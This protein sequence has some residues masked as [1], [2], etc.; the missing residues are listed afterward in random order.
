MFNRLAVAAA[1][2][3]VVS[4]TVV[5][6]KLPKRPRLPGEADTNNASAYHYFGNSVLLRDPKQ[7][8]DAYYWATRLNPRLAEAYYNRRIAL[9]LENPRRLAQYW[10]GQKSV[11]QSAEMQRIDSLYWR[12]LMLNPAL[13]QRFERELILAMIRSNI[14]PSAN[15]SPAELEMEFDT[16]VRGLMRADD[17]RARMAQ[18]RGDDQRALR[19]YASA[20]KQDPKVADIR[21]ARGRLFLQLGMADS[22]ISE[23]TQA[24]DMMRKEDKKEF[25]VFYNSK[26]MLETTIGIAHQQLSNLPAARDAFGRAL[27]EDLAY[28]PAHVWLGYV[29]L[30]LRDTTTALAELD[31]AVQLRADD[32]VLRDQYGYA[33]LIAGKADAAIE[34]LKKAAE[35]E[36]YYALPQWHLGEAYEAASNTKNALEAYRLFLVR[37]GNADPN[38]E[39]VSKRIAALAGTSQ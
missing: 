35:L 13:P 7:A 24:L 28:Y 36:P 4:S 27:Q 38:R 29:A 2:L 19:L 18:S 25:V 3:L 33:L 21:V 22:A 17:L 15:V 8:A 34:Q 10:R 30:E 6:Q 16:Y 23:L 39:T 20:A 11:V 32:G 9:L 37:A 31:L 5:A 12:A 26:A 1:A 14:D